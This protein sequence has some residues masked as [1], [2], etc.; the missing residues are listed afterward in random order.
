MTR[1]RGLIALIVAA[2]A[3]AAIIAVA[4][5]QSG[6]QAPPRS[7]RASAAAPVALGKAP[8]LAFSFGAPPGTTGGGTTGIGRT[9]TGP[10]GRESTYERP[11][12][13]CLRRATRPFRPPVSAESEPGEGMDGWGEVDG[14][15]EITRD[16]GFHWA[17][18]ALPANALQGARASVYEGVSSCYSRLASVAVLANAT[19]A[20][21]PAFER[22]PPRVDFDTLASGRSSWSE[23]TTR[24]VRDGE[25]APHIVVSEGVLIGLWMQVGGSA[26]IRPGRGTW[27]STDDGGEL[28]GA[29]GSRGR[30]NQLRARPVARQRT[31][32]VRGPDP[33]L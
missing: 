13:S 31:T 12:S 3:L 26:G 24:L 14:S 5:S 9:G 29:Q 17:R 22:Y 16:G 8:A 10:T 30:Q 2:L 27:A 20:V 7:A 15:P 32:P 28:A 25:Q 33:C 11:F 23:R 1:A 18:L 21:L 6:Q 4:S 19:I